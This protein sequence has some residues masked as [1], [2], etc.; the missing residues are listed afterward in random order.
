[1]RSIRGRKRGLKK[2]TNLNRHSLAFSLPNHLMPFKQVVGNGA[3]ALR[4][5]K[6]TEQ[7]TERRYD[8]GGVDVAKRLG[9]TF[10]TLFA[11]RSGEQHRSKAGREVV[12]CG[13]KAA[14]MRPK[15]FG[16]PNRPTADDSLPLTVV[17]TDVAVVPSEDDIAALITP[18]TE[19][20]GITLR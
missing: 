9:G 14:V 17:A 2:I 20:V 7:M 1:M 13:K 15:Y 10:V 11:V 6:H 3:L 19:E 8:I 16:R 4:R 5:W 12:L 18:L